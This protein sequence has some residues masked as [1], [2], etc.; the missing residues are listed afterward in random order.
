MRSWL[1][2]LRTLV[3]P[4]G[5]TSGKRI[6]LDGVNGLI[7][8]YDAVKKILQI[9]S[10]GLHVTGS[11]SEIDMTVDSGN[12]S[13]ITFTD[14]TQASPLT[15]LGRALARATPG[16]LGGLALDLWSGFDVNTPTSEHSRVL[17]SDNQLFMYH[18]DTSGSLA[19]G[20]QMLFLKDHIEVQKFM[21]VMGSTWVDSTLQN[22]WTNDATAEKMGTI[23]N[24]DGSVLFRGTITGGTRADGTIIANI[25]AA[26][27]PA[28]PKAFPVAA[29]GTTGPRCRIN[30]N[31][32]IQIF[33]TI[34]AGAVI[35]FDG[36]GYSLL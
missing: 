25:P 22:L 14:P 27:R 2:A 7:A 33:G 13:L 36:C 5:A 30:T 16:G 10:T 21:Q 29:N 17:I 18:S 19:G 34:A 15:W 24:P 4:Y 32:D 1:A 12:D 9:D 28:K 11:V 23:L 3:L 26:Y 6:V 8:V 31:G 20:A 35:S